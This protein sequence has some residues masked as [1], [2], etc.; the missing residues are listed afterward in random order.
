MEMKTIRNILAVIL[1]A[2]ISCSCVKEK[3]E[4]TYNKQEDTIDKYISSNLK[5][6]RTVTYNGGSARLTLVQGEGEEL[7]PGGTV[8]F[9]YAGYIFNG[10][11]SSSSLFATNHEETATSS[12]L[13]LTDADYSLLE[14]SLEDG[15]LLEG[16][17]NGLAGVRVGEECEILFCGKYGFGNS[18]FGMIPANSALAFQ[19][20]VVSVSNDSP[21]FTFFTIFVGSNHL[22]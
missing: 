7:E 8:G 18:T 6:D 1:L 5:D 20:W 17:R 12:K 14:V 13:V 19:I 21:I 10:S 9:Y 2:A 22:E 16:V 15:K 4:M 3:L 11:L